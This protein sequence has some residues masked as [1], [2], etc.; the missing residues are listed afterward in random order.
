MSIRP[1]AVG[2]L[3]WGLLVTGAVAQAEWRLA[4]GAPGARLGVRLAFDSVRGRTVLFGGGDPTFV[5]DTW[6]FGNGA[7][8]RLATNDG[9]VVSG[10]AV[11]FDTA[12]D[13][14]VVVGSGQTWEFDGAAWV[15]RLVANPPNDVTHEGRMAYDASRGV[16]VLYGDGQTWEWDG[17]S[18]VHVPSSLAPGVLR[19]HQVVYHAGRQRVMLHGGTFGFFPNS[20]TYP[21]LWE[22]D[23]V[24]WAL[25]DSSGPVRE[26]HG[27][28][29]DAARN[30]LVVFGGSTTLADVWEWDETSWQ[31]LSPSPAP[32]PRRRFG[33]TYDAALGSVVLYGG[34]NMLPLGPTLGDTWTWNGA[35]WSQSSSSTPPPRSGSTMTYDKVRGKAI[36]H[37]GIRGL[38]TIGE[39][40]EL[41]GAGW[42]QITPA[43]F[44]VAR[45]HDM[46]FDDARGLTVLGAADQVFDY[47]G[48]NWEWRGIT[49]ASIGT[50]MA[51]DSLRGRTLF[52]GGFQDDDSLRAY[53][54]VSVSVVPTTSTSPQARWMH[55]MVYDR[56]RDRVIVYGGKDAGGWP[57][58]DGWEFDGQQWQPIPTGPGPR[59][60][61]VMVYDE[62]R[63]RTLLQGGTGAV[64]THFTDTWE[65]DG[66]VWTQVA[67][68]LPVSSDHAAAYDSENARVVACTDQSAVWEYSTAS[69]ARVEVV[70]TGCAGSVGVPSLTAAPFGLPWLGDPLVVEAAPFATQATPFILFGREPAALD[71]SVIGAPGCI[72]GLDSYHAEMLPNASGTASWSVVVPID[73]ALA[74]QTFHT[75]VVAVDVPANPL[76]VVLSDV[77]RI[78]AG[79]R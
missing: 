55:G 22:W 8:L 6:T 10:G 61:F 74:S 37:G 76:G 2:A 47:D 24:D 65:W 78:V 57:I 29:Y 17:L 21:N 27:L 39:T 25:V 59:Y 4:E 52:F 64:G 12:R 63:D 54:G 1:F 32:A 31:Q 19:D 68:V 66:T 75:Q 44:P 51:Y 9:H 45:E 11:S 79:I 34:D 42:Q 16:S 53:D 14:L 69:R 15:Q 72:L 60:R 13:R 7:W 58:A 41:D 49:Q 36:L 20:I 38:A 26:A 35:A 73:T 18:W 56:R 70:G 50:R 77:A 62:E 40:W 67:S 3:V 30:R 23:G 48:V 5:S 33:I 71:L 28:A 43:F 46:V